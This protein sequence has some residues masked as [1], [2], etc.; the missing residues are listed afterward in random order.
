MASDTPVV[1]VLLEQTLGHVSH[2]RNLCRT[3]AEVD[4]AEVV[5]RELPFDPRRRLDRLPPMSNWTVRSSLAARREL[6][7]LEQRHRLDALIVHTHVPATMLG[8]SMSRIPTVVSIDATPR[9]IDQLGGSYNHKV[10]P[11]MVESAKRGLHRRCF[12]D[13]AALVTWSKWAAGSLIDDYGVDPSRITVIPPGVVPHVW[14]RQEPRSGADDTVRILFVGGDFE[15]KGGD[16]LV[17]AFDRLRQDPEL[18]SDGLSVELHLVTSADVPATPSVHVHRGL[19]PNS[20]ELIDLFHRCDIFALPTRGDCTPVVLAEAA[21][22]GL[23]SVATD[24]GAI[25]ESVLD[26]TTGHLVEPTVESVYEALRLLVLD[27]DHRLRLGQNAIDHAAKRMNSEKNAEELLQ[28]AV[29]AAGRPARD[30]RVVLT[31]SGTV[32]PDTEDAVAAKIRPMADYHAIGEAADAQLIDWNTLRHDGSKL[33]NILRRF[34]GNS[35][36]LAHHLYQ[37]RDSF[38]AVVTD[39]EQ[40]G[41]PLA[42][43]LRLAGPKNFRHVMIG[44]RLSPTKKAMLTRLF[45]L[46]RGVDEVLV[47]SSHQERVAERLFDP[48]RTKIRRIDFMVDTEFFRP[49][50]SIADGPEGSRPLLCAAGREFR[51]YPTLIEAVRDLDVDVVIAS[52]SPWSRRADNARTVDYPSNVTITALNQRKLRDLLDASDMLV[53]P[54]LETDFQAGIT[55]I[56]EAMS[57]ERPV[58]CTATQGQTDVVVDG[59]NGAYVPPADVEALRTAIEKMIADRGRAARMGANGRRLV[60]ERADVR[61][62]ASLF[63]EIVDDHL[64]ERSGAEADPRLVQ[65]PN[66]GDAMLARLN[67]PIDGKRASLRSVAGMAE[68]ARPSSITN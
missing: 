62:Y 34:A 21:T 65:F 10:Q 7:A 24:V 55:T 58:I 49:T 11:G 64:P 36:A 44:H 43:L 50:R 25:S 38:D 14:Q 23:P 4:H 53:M 54:L 61:R 35:V 12:N 29:D 57:M 8:Q 45:D 20:P 42:A 46:S 48:K 33:T 41:L 15:R 39:G 22:A 68:Q 67:R 26:G 52:A 3:F 28:V 6:R 5:W 60:E 37:Q 63:G 31:V 51:D 59:V 13:A 19:T 9:Q 27:R 66:G 17:G 40:V 1:G 2:G 18:S 56:L 16:L 47:Y 32:S 30:R